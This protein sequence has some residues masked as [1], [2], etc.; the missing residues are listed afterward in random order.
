MPHREKRKRRHGSELSQDPKSK[1]TRSQNSKDEKHTI[2]SRPDD[3][4]VI[5]IPFSH[6]SRPCPVN[7]K[8]NARSFSSTFSNPK[9]DGRRE[10]HP[11]KKACPKTSAKKPNHPP[12][13]PIEEV[14]R[15]L[16]RYALEFLEQGFCEYNKGLT[17]EQV[18][19]CGRQVLDSYRTNADVIRRL[20]LEEDLE[21]VGFTTF[22]LRHA[23]RFDLTISEFADRGKKR[24]IIT[25]NIC[26][27][28]LVLI[29]ADVGA[30]DLF[31]RF[32]MSPYVH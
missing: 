11:A 32:E 19:M 28:K 29:L 7:N 5:L 17:I 30:F 20:N 31:P 23:G 4:N 6:N 22:K 8:G 10:H 27:V 2:V 9:R 15:N 25:S 1:T 26:N 3:A 14:P 18:L 24:A 21:K 13:V 16:R 12:G